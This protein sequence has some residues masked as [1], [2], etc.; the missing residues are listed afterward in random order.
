MLL[1]LIIG[2]LLG[3][4]CWPHPLCGVRCLRERPTS[5]QKADDTHEQE[6]WIQSQ[7]FGQEPGGDG[8]NQNPHRSAGVNYRGA[9]SL[10]R[11]L[12]TV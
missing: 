11:A 8:S 6:S 5:G 2:T 4:T 9:R 1:R 12:N 3:A 7:A 10:G